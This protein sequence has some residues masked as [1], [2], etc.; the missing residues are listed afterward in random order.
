MV[1]KNYKIVNKLKRRYLFKEKKKYSNICI[2]F[3]A[4]KVSQ[5]D[6]LKAAE[7]NDKNAADSASAQCS[8]G[9][10][11]KRQK[12]SRSGDNEA[13]Q[14]IWR[15]PHGRMPASPHSAPHSLCPLQSNL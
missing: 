7:I 2:S 5:T 15:K 4:G 13:L 14:G 8:A 3:R 9:K 11:Q 6:W 12:R 1:T 10:I